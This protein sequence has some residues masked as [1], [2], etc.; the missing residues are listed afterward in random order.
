MNRV[1]EWFEKK[2]MEKAREEAKLLQKANSCIAAMP[3]LFPNDISVPKPRAHSSSLHQAISEIKSK[4]RKSKS[5]ERAKP[6]HAGSDSEHS[7]LPDPDVS[8]KSFPHNNSPDH[9]SK[10]SK[11]V[12]GA[13]E[14]A[15]QMELD[16]MRAERLQ[17]E[18]RERERA[19]VVMAKAMGLSTALADPPQTETPTDERQL[20]FNSAFNPE[21]S[22]AL[23]ERRQRWRESKRNSHL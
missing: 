7:P 10:S 8:E 17:R 3:S 19:A 11:S 12:P 15:K 2:R 6:K 14:L 1:S 18:R 4:H 21:L 22:A 23:A 9:C 16:R 5:K 20:P 13:V